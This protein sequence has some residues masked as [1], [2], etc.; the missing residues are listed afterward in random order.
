[1]AETLRT[2]FIPPAGVCINQTREGFLMIHYTVD[3]IPAMRSKLEALSMSLLE[4]AITQA[5]L[6]KRT[7]EERQQLPQTRMQ[8][9]EAEIAAL[10]SQRPPALPTV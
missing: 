2:Q 10:E 4:E 6:K 8:A 3:M 7:E 1:M 9:I 5:K